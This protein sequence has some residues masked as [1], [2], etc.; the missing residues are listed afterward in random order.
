MEPH[1]PRQT[2]PEP[3]CETVQVE[4][5]VRIDAPCADVWRALCDA[6]ELSEWL[7]GE[8]VL[9][10]P[11][12][13]G[14]AGALRSDDGDRRLLV[15]EVEPEHR[16]AWLWWR[17]SGELS[18]V[19]LTTRP[20]GDATVVRVVEVVALDASAPRTACRSAGG[21]RASFGVDVAGSWDLA[22][23]SLV[24]RLAVRLGALS[25]R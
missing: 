1:S 2:S 5:S 24:S 18:T 6:D 7:G 4:R 19:E 13:P 3:A 8:V 23:S 22:L 10:R 14:A 20:D 16:L 11:L 21:S 9:D 15:T 17:E 12:A 25:A